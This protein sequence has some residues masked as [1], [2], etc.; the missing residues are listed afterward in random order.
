[1]YEE[2][3][4]EVGVFLFDEFANHLV[5]QGESVSPSRIHGCLTGL[6]AA[7]GPVEAG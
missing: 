4:T 3:S 6:L 1:M 7:G 5:E 2:L